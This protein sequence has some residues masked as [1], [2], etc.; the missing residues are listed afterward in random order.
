MMKILYRLFLGLIYLII[1]RKME[2]KILSKKYQ[3]RR[4]LQHRKK[5]ILRKRICWILSKTKRK[6]M[7]LILTFWRNLWK[8]NLI[9]FNSYKMNRKVMPFKFKMMFW[10]DVKKMKVLF[11]SKM[12][13]LC[14]VRT[15]I[16]QWFLSS[17]SQL[18]S[19]KPIKLCWM[20]LK[21]NIKQRLCL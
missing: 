11:S 9:A 6:R 17:P 21:K 8:P 1:N 20:K 13:K 12:M 15:R 3:K 4:N 7:S 18:T 5:A 2:L 19:I 10:M 14:S 16:S